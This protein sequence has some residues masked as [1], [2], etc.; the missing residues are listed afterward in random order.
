MMAPPL[1]PIITL[2]HS[3]SKHQQQNNVIDD[4]SR[5]R[6]QNID[7]LVEQIASHCTADYK[8][9]Y[10]FVQL[11]HRCSLCNLCFCLSELCCIPLISSI[12]HLLPLSPSPFSLPL[13]LIFSDD[14]S[15]LLQEIIVEARN[16]SDA[17]M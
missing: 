15:V 9:S 13:S 4:S 12:F 14:V 17:E 10:Q 8:S 6:I 7:P 3:N 1:C 2:S 11:I 5:L 16:L